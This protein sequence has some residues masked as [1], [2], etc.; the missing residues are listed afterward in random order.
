MRF[1]RNVLGLSLVLLGF[2][3]TLVAGAETTALHG[4]SAAETSWAPI[5]A[6]TTWRVH[7]TDCEPMMWGGEP[8]PCSLLWTAY[9]IAVVSDTAAELV[10]ELCSLSCSAVELLHDAAHETM[11]QAEEEVLECEEN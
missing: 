2:T 10:L 8:G 9:F 11:D 7:A 6:V 4:L 3:P 5:E 1:T